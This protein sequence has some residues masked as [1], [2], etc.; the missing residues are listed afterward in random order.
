MGS[1]PKIRRYT[2][3]GVILVFS[4]ACAPSAEPDDSNPAASPNAEITDTI[5]SSDEPAPSGVGPTPA[6]SPNTDPSSVVTLSPTG[7]LSLRAGPQLL[8]PEQISKQ[9][10][11]LFNLR[12]GYTD[13]QGRF[14]DNF[15]EGHGR[16]FGGIDFR[17][18]FDR[19][20]RVKV[21]TALATRQ[22]ANWLVGALC[23]KADEIR[24]GATNLFEN[25]DTAEARPRIA[26]FDSNLSGASLIFREQQEKKWKEQMEFL[27]KH[28]FNRNITPEELQVHKELFTE[29][30][31]HQTQFT[32]AA[33]AATLY[34][35][36]VSREFWTR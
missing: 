7:Y 20:P 2:C 8:T 3:L 18:T 29:V 35:I 10:E 24:E 19:D 14:R 17:N 25:T 36:F 27:Y 22:I 21:Q 32:P 4:K 28:I 23:C 26:K 5:V 1:L 9:I 31:E 12:D 15:I 34:A 33:W 6:G 11:T 16:S 30:F 13:N